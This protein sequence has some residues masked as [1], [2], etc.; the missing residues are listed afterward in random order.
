M[1]L[2]RRWRLQVAEAFERSP[3]RCAAVGTVS[4]TSVEFGH[5][6]AVVVDEEEGFVVAVVEVRNPDRAAEGTAFLE[7]AVA[8]ARRDRPCRRIDGVF[9]EVLVGVE[10]L[11]P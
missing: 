2:V 4:V 10:R 3:L 1:R 11:V 7:E 8:V 6:G 9:M 5:G